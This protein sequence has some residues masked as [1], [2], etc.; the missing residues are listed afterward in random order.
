MTASYSGFVNGDTPAR[1]TT[2]PTFTT[3]ATAAS[4]VSGNPYAIVV[5]GAADPDY[6]ITCVGGSLTV[7]PAPLTI[8]ADSKNMPYGGPLPSLTA[9]Y[10]GF[11]HGDTPA[12]LTAPPTLTT[13]VPATSRVSG[14]P[15]PITAGGA[16]DSDY[17][18]SY[19]G[20]WLTVTAATLTVTP[21]NKTKIY[22]ST[23]T[24]FTGTISGLQ[25]GDN[26]TA[27]Y[28]SSGAAATAGVSGNP[29]PI[30]ASLNDP[31]GKLA[32]YA[33]TVN[34][35]QLTVVPAT[36]TITADSQTKLYGAPLPSL[37][38]TYS[39]LVDGDTASSLATPPTLSTPATAGSPVAL[40]AI[41]AAGAADPNYTISYVAGTLSITPAPLTITANDASKTYG[42]A[43]PQF[44]A[45]YT[46]F[47]NGDGPG[48]LSNMPAFTTNEPADALPGIYKITP[49][50]ATAANY[51]AVYHTG[52]LT[53]TQ[54]AAITTAMTVAASAQQASYGDAVTITA[55]VS[56]GSETVNSG[57]VTFL[58]GTTPIGSPV[59]MCQGQAKL[60]YSLLPAGVHILN[61]VYSGDGV[62][63][64]GSTAASSFRIVV[65]PT[66]LT[67]TVKNAGKTYGGA[68]PQFAINYAGFVNREGPGV[69]AGTLT[70]TT[71]EPAGEN[72]PAGAYQVVP[73]GLTFEQ[74]CDHLSKRHADGSPGFA[75]DHRG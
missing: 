47:V 33:V 58:D 25:N 52:T 21:D 61:A 14:T 26:I 18:I 24:A 6:T 4:H 11:V 44:S 57:T 71:T 34:Q 73:A 27:S 49:A 65:A 54:H 10:S 23:F 60:A 35:G 17:T 9:S 29:Y 38:A 40:Y 36:L 7:A 3:A 46:G 66:P 75:D 32:N 2:P 45:S 39:G 42:S 69:L 56:A 30:T 13:T 62:N 50:G 16:V 19:V 8:T 12:S 59:P 48:V 68:D 64:V 28:S 15:Y 53:V 37:T 31:N 70:L 63:F 20:G 43:D 55:T 1:L 67:V 41:T 51:A 22:G 74:L 5:G 72:A